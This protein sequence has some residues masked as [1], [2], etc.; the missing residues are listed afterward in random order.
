LKNIGSTQ[1]E[2]GDFDQPSTS[3]KGRTQK[4]PIDY[5]RRSREN[6]AHSFAKQCSY[7]LAIGVTVAKIIAAETGNKNL[8]N[9]FKTIL[10]DLSDADDFILLRKSNIP[11]TMPI[12]MTDMEATSWLIDYSLSKR[13]YMDAREEWMKRNAN[14]LPPYHHIQN[15]KLE[16]RPKDITVTDKKAFTTI[17]SLSTHT[18]ERIVDLR[19]AKINDLLSQTKEDIEL[20]MIFAYGGDGTTGLSEYN[21]ND[22][23]G[24]PIDDHSLFVTSMT[25]LLLK[26]KSQNQEVWKILTP[27]SC[28][29]NRTISLEYVK[30]SKEHVVNT[31]NDLREQI[32]QLKPIILNVSGNE[33][34]VHCQFYETMFDGKILSYVTDTSTR[35]CGLCKRSQKDFKCIENLINGKFK[36]VDE[37]LLHGLCPL[38]AIICIFKFLIQIASRKVIESWKVPENKQDLVNEKEKQILENLQKEFG[39]ICNKPRAGGAGNSTTGKVCRKAFNSPKVF[40]KVLDLD[41]KIIENF[42][43]VL[44]VLNAHEKINQEKFGKLCTDTYKLLLTK[45]KWI[46]M[47]PTAHK[48]LAHSKDVIMVLPLPPGYFSEEGP[49]RRNKDYKSFRLFHARHFSRKANLEDVFTRSLDSSDPIMSTARMNLR[50]NKRKIIPLRPEVKQFLIFDEDNSGDEMEHEMNF[51]D[52]YAQLLDNFQINM[53]GKE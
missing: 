3:K 36:A 34:K 5:G 10:K 43:I 24:S 51:A 15:I 22:S 9:I 40:A 27:Q 16:C 38:H 32:K 17:K 19:K 42:S 47:N 2:A 30:E 26:T 18:V 12:M 33:I 31:F 25:P 6:M 29:F 8:E 49:E 4:D 23:K 48:V 45:Y 50:R 39:I 35:S 11:N 20:E 28:R 44:S 46:E 52:N 1:T 13:E 41:E 14:V 53:K 7:S 37:F 21:L